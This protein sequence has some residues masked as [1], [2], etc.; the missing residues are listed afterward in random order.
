VLGVAAFFA[1][2]VWDVRFVGVA[3]APAKSRERA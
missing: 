1:R 2:I 3:P